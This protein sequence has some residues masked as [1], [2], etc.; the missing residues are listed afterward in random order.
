MREPASLALLLL[1]LLSS[2]I[3]II[4]LLGQ[5]LGVDTWPLVNMAGKTMDNPRLGLFSDKYWDRHNNRWPGI[6]S[7]S[8]VLS[9]AMG[10]DVIDTYMYLLPTALEAALVLGLYSFFRRVTR[11]YASI[12]VGLT[13]F[14]PPVF[15]FIQEPVKEVLSASIALPLLLVLVVPPG[16]TFATVTALLVLSLGMIVSHPLTPLI[17]VL[18]GL[19]AVLVA[20]ALEAINLEENP[21]PPRTALYVSLVTAVYLAYNLGFGFKSTGYAGLIRD[22]TLVYMLYLYFAASLYIYYNTGVNKATG[23]LTLALLAVGAAGLALAPRFLPRTGL[24][25]DYTVYIL[26]LPVALVSLA[27]LASVERD[28]WYTLVK[29][30]AGSG[31]LVVGSMALFIASYAQILLSI[32]HR[33][34]HYLYPLIG[35]AGAHASRRNTVIP[36]VALAILVAASLFLAVQIIR[37]QDPVRYTWRYTPGETTG[38]TEIVSMANTT[39][40]GDEKLQYYYTYLHAVKQPLNPMGDTTPVEGVFITY[41]DMMRYGFWRSPTNI[42]S[43]ATVKQTLTRSRGAVYNNGLVEAYILG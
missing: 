27:P 25:V 37:D 31:L 36:G 4:Y 40:L 34:L 15:M 12:G 8:I 6:V 10:V 3:G 16:N 9:R 22:Y 14:S 2:H 32:I 42:I 21:F 41:K 11:G 28:K 7:L 17:L 39:L 20:R 5:P 35:L 26:S 24:G 18:T 23:T 29:H 43:P 30:L 38:Y 13:L 33:V 1:L 19:T